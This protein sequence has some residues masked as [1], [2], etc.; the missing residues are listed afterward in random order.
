M[1]PPEQ[2]KGNLIRHKRIGSCNNSNPNT[3]R[4]ENEPLP[5]DVRYAAPEQEEAAEG[6]GVGGYD[7]LQ[8]GFGD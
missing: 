8:T 3:P 2:I 6:E 7:P 5:V 1:Q 4:N